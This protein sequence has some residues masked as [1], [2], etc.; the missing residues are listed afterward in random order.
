[1]R[2]LIYLIPL[3]FVACNL[4]PVTSEEPQLEGDIDARHTERLPLDRGWV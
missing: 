3:L 4:A 2:W 1:M